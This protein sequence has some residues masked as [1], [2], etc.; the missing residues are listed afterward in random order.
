MAE[1]QA[2]RLIPD[3]L[4]YLNSL[5]KIYQSQKKF[6]QAE[7]L[8]SRIIPIREAHKLNFWQTCQIEIEK[9]C[10][11]VDSIV[12]ALEGMGL[13]TEIES[14]LNMKRESVRKKLE[15][16]IPDWANDWKMY[17]SYPCPAGSF[18]QVEGIGEFKITDNNDCLQSRLARKVPWELPV[19]L[20]LVET[21]PRLKNGIVVEI[22]ANIGSHSVLL[23]YLFEGDVFLYEPLKFNFSLLKENIKR[24]SNKFD[25]GKVK[26]IELSFKFRIGSKDLKIVDSNL[27]MA[28][29]DG[30]DFI[31]AES[32]E[33]RTLD[34]DIQAG[35]KV[36]LI[37]M[38]VEGHEVSVIKG[39]ARIFSESKPIVLIEVWQQ[40]FSELVQL[41]NEFDYDYYHL[42]RS[43]W[44]FYPRSKISQVN[45]HEQKRSVQEVFTN[46]Y[47]NNNWQSAESVSGTGSSLL[48]TEVIRKELPI[49]LK[50]LNIQTIID[51]PCG[52][53]HWMS[54][55]V[56]DIEQYFGFDIVKEIINTNHKKYANS[57][58]SI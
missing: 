41:M 8:E 39:A 42:F 45:S 35:Q 52:D 18:A 25:M 23:P 14:Q 26:L 5:L 13:L 19:A 49:L 53:F 4:T 38:D 40:N 20:F 33:V 51:I 17:A 22:G 29:L 15:Q 28:R 46:I 27:G 55:I 32:V 56:L 10:G 54:Q 24:N 44:V 6:K 21:L 16:S 31:S 1:K 9:C 30:E 43:D 12:Q 36:S 34:S 7:E 37:K 50:E 11:K 47:K 58:I 3:N 57:K 48:A 2:I